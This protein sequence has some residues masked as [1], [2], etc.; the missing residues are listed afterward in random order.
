M[1][2]LNK[3][4]MLTMKQRKRILNMKTEEEEALELFTIS[5]LL[6]MCSME[7]AD[8]IAFLRYHGLIEFPPFL[9]RVLDD[10]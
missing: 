8:A 2:Q 1:I 6:E 10:E 9:T 7:E 3:L 4:V 5:E